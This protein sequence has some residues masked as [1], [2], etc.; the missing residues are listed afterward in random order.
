[1]DGAHKKI[2][3]SE[4]GWAVQEIGAVKDERSKKK[5]GTQYKASWGDD[6]KTIDN[7]KQN[8]IEKQSWAE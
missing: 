7:I 4:S 6:S 2:W 8:V 5:W 1:M 3:G